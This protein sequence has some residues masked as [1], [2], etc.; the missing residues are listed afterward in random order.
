MP[1]LR[2]GM[3]DA[4]KDEPFSPSEKH[5]KRTKY[6]TIHEPHNKGFNCLRLYYSSFEA[7]FIQHW[8]QV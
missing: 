8:N 5:K 2:K 3:K 7:H 6:Q 4:A 1:S